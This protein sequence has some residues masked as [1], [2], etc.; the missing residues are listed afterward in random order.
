M[1]PSQALGW[2]KL[3]QRVLWA[4]LLITGLVLWG[5]Q[6]FVG[7]LGLD[8]FI[9]TY[10]MYLGVVFLLF[11]AATLPTPIQ[12]VASKAW[13]RLQE[14][15]HKKTRLARLHDLSDDEKEVLRHYLQNNTRTHTLDCTDGVA[16]A[17]EHARII[18]RASNLSQGYTDFAYNIQQWAHDYLREHPEVLDEV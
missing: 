1:D 8:Q 7:G 11:L 3:P 2:L 13:A 9:E 17:L 16:T 5:P 12:W 10:R 14:Q 4:L 15:R 6:W 18:Y